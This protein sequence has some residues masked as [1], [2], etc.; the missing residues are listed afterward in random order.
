MLYSQR[1]H[2]HATI[3]AAL[4]SRYLGNE[5]KV[6]DLLAYH[7]ARSND[8]HKALNYMQRAGQKALDGY[9]NEAA[10]TYFSDAL[11]IARNDLDNIKV[12]YDLLAARERAYNCLGNRAA[13]TEDLAQMK[14]LAGGQ[15]NQERLLETGNRQLQLATDL[16]EYTQAIDI[17]ETLLSL[18][19]GVGEPLWEVRT[20]TNLGVTYWRHGEYTKTR[21]CMLQALQNGDDAHNTLLRATKLNYLGLVHTQLSEYEQ[22]RQDYQQALDI[23]QANR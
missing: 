9:A 4:E 17:A 11:N 19:R 1:Q 13:Q 23:Y 14:T 15:N 8:K 10:I 6:I 18:A 16:A 5:D 20:L 12:Q 7:Y 21:E 22:A 3:G 2:L